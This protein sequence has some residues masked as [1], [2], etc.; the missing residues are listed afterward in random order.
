MK[1]GTF[2]HIHFIGK[3]TECVYTIFFLN[4]TICRYNYALYM[5]VVPVVYVVPVLHV[6]PV[7]HVIYV[8]HVA[9][10]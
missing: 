3:V 1:R 8:V 10:L 4:F 5:V 9:H 2:K 7:V 6:I